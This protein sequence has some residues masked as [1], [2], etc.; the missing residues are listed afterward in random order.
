MDAWGFLLFLVGIVGL[1]VLFGIVAVAFDF[2]K[3]VRERELAHEERMKSLELGF[4]LP[5]A[6]LARSGAEKTRTRATATIA[7]GVP[8]LVLAA[9]SGATFGVLET[10]YQ[11]Q[12]TMPLLVTL[13]VLAA[14]VILVTVVL[15]FYHLRRQPQAAPSQSPSTRAAAEAAPGLAAFKE[16]T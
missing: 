10:S 15:G 12:R 14:L 2:R 9:A 16:R 6:D 13:W 5:D 4:S 7:I 3:K 1:M 11:H 8:I